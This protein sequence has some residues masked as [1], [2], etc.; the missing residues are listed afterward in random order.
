MFDVIVP[1]LQAPVTL[2]QQYGE[3][4]LILFGAGAAGVA[5]NELRR[6]RNKAEADGKEDR[7]ELKKVTTTLNEMTLGFREQKEVIALLVSEHKST[8]LLLAGEQRKLQ[9]EISRRLDTIERALDVLPPGRSR[10]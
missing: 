5:L 6:S 3:G 9:E 10:Q 4:L 7:G 1:A 2:P 8:L